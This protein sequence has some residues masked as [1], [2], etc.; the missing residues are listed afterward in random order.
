MTNYSVEVLSGHQWQKLS[1]S[2]HSVVF[3]EV[4]RAGLE[5]ADHA[6]IVEVD[7]QMGGYFTCKVMDRDT[8][9]IQ[10]GGVFPGFEKSVH[11][12]PGYRAMVDFA[13]GSFKN[14]WTRIENKNTPMLKLALKLGFVPTGVS[15]F[16][17]KL[18]VEM[19]MEVSV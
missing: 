14:I 5:R 3:G 15:Q 6:L 18:F 8:L 17:D 12:L 19:S 1:E 16:K 2:I 4:G 10:Y 13:R 9:Y 11:V 7:G